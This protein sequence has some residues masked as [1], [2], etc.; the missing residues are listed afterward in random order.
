M[1]LALQTQPE[2]LDEVAT[3]YF[4]AF[5]LLDNFRNINGD[6]S[7]CDIVKHAE[8]IGDDPLEFTSIIVKIDKAYKSVSKEDKTIG[9]DKSEEK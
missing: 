9:G 2:D 8:L 5:V 6:L 3:Q 4:Q 7:F 1:P